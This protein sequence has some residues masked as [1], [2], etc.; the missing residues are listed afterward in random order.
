MLPGVHRLTARE[1]FSAARRDGQ[2]WRSPLLA[3]N[4]LRR[5]N[6][7]S[8]FGFVVNRQ[9]G[10]ATARNR[11]KRRLREGIRSYLGVMPSGYDVVIIARPA[12]AAATY[13]EL[14]AA[15]SELLAQAR[16]L[17]NGGKGGQS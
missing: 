4:L 9:V 12:A 8:R 13:G 1:D 11:L 3:L 14:R 10:K 15:L 17:H 5:G 7:A 16:L 2:R 6:D